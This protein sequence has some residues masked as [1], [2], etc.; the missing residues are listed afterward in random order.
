MVSEDFHERISDD[1][2]WREKELREADAR[3]IRSKKVIEIKSSILITYSH[4][5]VHFKCCAL[6]LLGFISEGIKRKLFKWTDIR[7]EV[8][9]RILFCSY[10]RS[11]LAGQTQETFITYLNALNDGRYA[12]V[13]KGSDEIIM[14]DDNLN[15]MRAEAICR[16]LGVE[17]SWCALKK[18]VIDERILEY[19]NAIAHGARRL[20]SGDEMDLSGPDIIEAIDETRLLMREAKNRFQNTINNRTFLRT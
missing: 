5:E 12:D 17:H 15:A 13:L 7:T 10:R 19:R 9:E 11:S 16:N 8:R 1:W 3:L 6:E 2:L 14:I 4:W 20:R 18:V